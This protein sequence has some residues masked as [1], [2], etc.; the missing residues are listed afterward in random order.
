MKKKFNIVSKIKSTRTFRL[1]RLATK[2]ISLPGFDDMPLYDV[3][4]FFVRGLSDGAIT[5]RASSVAYKFFIAMFPAIIFLFTLIPY[6]PIANFQNT[7]L[8]TIRTALPVNVNAMINETITDIIARQHGGL[9][10]LGFILA[11]Y[12]SSNGI[13][14]LITAFNATAHQIETRKWWQQYAVSIL[15]MII[16]TLIVILSITMI[17]L[18]TSGLNYLI[19]AHIIEESVLLFIIRISKWITIVLMIFF[20]VSFLYYLGPVKR[21]EFRFISA[22]STLAT[23]LF[24][25][26]TLGFKYYVDNFA[27]YN[28]VY[29][30]I[31]TV[32]VILMWLYFNSLALLMG[33]EL[34][35]SILEAKKTKSVVAVVSKKTKKKYAAAAK[36]ASKNIDKT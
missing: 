11:L 22:G 10:S 5:T 35:A 4:V 34:N 14:G 19:S 7:L 2:K 32:I 8:E 26:S 27:S 24:I 36:K 31:G 17:M 16:L 23:L 9:L 25:A 30:S 15:L 18:G 33:F 3:V 21:K 12:F 20:G 13:L 28:A 6:L 29:G 1:I